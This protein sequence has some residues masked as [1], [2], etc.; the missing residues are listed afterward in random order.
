MRAGGGAL[1]IGA[2]SGEAKK[3]L[4]L[5]RTEKPGVR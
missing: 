1:L 4:L 2:S 3:S 5:P